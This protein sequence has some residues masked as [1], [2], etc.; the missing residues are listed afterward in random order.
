M[1]EIKLTKN[2]A[3]VLEVLESHQ[4]PLT[5]YTILERLNDSGLRAPPQVYRALDKLIDLGLIHKLES[6]NSFIACQ[7]R[8]CTFHNQITSF[9]ICESCQCVSEI[10]N[11]EFEQT[12][13]MVWR[14]TRD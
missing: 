9:A 5:A 8:H 7:H 6:I 2:Q 10:V 1:S 13:L 11:A 4:S 14:R 3:L 12:L